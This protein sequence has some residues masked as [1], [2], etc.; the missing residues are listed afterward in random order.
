M[1]PKVVPA[2]DPH[3]DF[4][5]PFY[6]GNYWDYNFSLLPIFMPLPLCAIPNTYFWKD[7]ILNPKVLYPR[8]LN[9]PISWKGGGKLKRLRVESGAEEE[10]MRERKAYR[11]IKSIVQE[12]LQKE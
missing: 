1:G 7:T 9:L 6:E 4:H 2:N 8:V 5:P 11:K 3:R 12:D 10:K